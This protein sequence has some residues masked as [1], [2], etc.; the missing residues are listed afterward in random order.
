MYLLPNCAS[1]SPASGD[2]NLIGHHICM[3]RKNMKEAIQKLA[4]G[5]ERF[6]PIIIADQGYE[7]F[8]NIIKTPDNF[9]DL[10]DL[11]TEC[12]ALFLGT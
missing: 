5:S 7:V 1:Q 10:R 8:G 11:I 3:Q 6:F 2:G 9:L 12:G 4:S